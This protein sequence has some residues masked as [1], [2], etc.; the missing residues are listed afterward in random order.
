MD[1]T[2]RPVP[3]DH[4]HDSLGWSLP[5]LQWND[6]WT[7]RLPLG[8]SG[9]ALERDS[10]CRHALVY[11]GDAR[12]RALR[13]LK[14]S[15]GPGV[16]S[17]VHSWTTALYRDLRCNHPHARADHESTGPVRHRSRGSP[18]RIHRCHRGSDRRAFLLD[19]RRADIDVWVATR[20]AA[21]VEI[22][23][24][25]D[26]RLLTSSGR[27]AAPSGRLCSLVRALRDVVESDS[28]RSTR[29]RT[30]RLCLVGTSPTNHGLC[31]P[32][33]AHRVGFPRLARM[34]CL[35]L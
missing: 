30:C 4:L 1:L 24:L 11:S 35:G 20:R 12:I 3:P 10:V 9:Y 19:C 18:G 6:P 27:R 34:V 13:A 32:A 17:L 25:A 22:H 23:G 8:A 16:A 2:T 15:S 28:H 33:S 29:R 31:G 14:N 7:G 5:D 26:H 21:A